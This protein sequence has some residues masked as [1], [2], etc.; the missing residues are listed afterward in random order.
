MLAAE[1][2]GIKKVVLPREN[3]AD[4]TELPAE[5]RKALDFVLADSLG[6][7]LEAALDGAGPARGPTRVGS[8]ERKAASPA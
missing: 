6:E 8:P 1:R 2:A 7:V 4:L 3:E 5:T